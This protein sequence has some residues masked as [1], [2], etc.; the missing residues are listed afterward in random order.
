MG[1]ATSA[2]CLEAVSQDDLIPPE[3]C[4]LGSSAARAER[5]TLEDSEVAT[6]SMMTKP[7]FMMIGIHRCELEAI[8]RCLRIHE[9]LVGSSRRSAA[10][11]AT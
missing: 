3:N 7:N 9:A 8:C 1:L 4:G 6:S 2:S 5:S 10:L 11:P